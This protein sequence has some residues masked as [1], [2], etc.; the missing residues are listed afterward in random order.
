[1]RRL[2]G[3]LFV[4]VVILALLAGLCDRLWRSHVAQRELGEPRVGSESLSR[5]LLDNPYLEPDTAAQA[6]LARA[7]GSA[8]PVLVRVAEQGLSPLELRF[9]QL[10]QNWQNHLPPALRKAT[11]RWITADPNR[12]AKVMLLLGNLGPE[13]SNAVPTLLRL[14]RVDFM[15]TGQHARIALLKI[16]PHDPEVRALELAWLSSNSL[17]ASYYFQEAHCTY[18]EAPPILLR[19]LIADPGGTDNELLALTQYGA[20]ASNALPTVRTLFHAG[21][22]NALSVMLAMG[23]PAAPA[24]EE[25]AALLGGT[26]SMDLRILDGLRRIG[27]GAAITLPRVEPYLTA[28][29]PVTRLLAEATIASLRG[30]PTAVLPSFQRALEAHRSF[31]TPYDIS[32]PLLDDHVVYPLGS[33]GMACWFAGEMGPSAAPV[34][35]SLEA[36]FDDEH[37]QLRVLAA[38]GHWRIALQ[39]EQVLPVLRAVLRVPDPPVREL[40]ICALIE[41]GPP[42]AAAEPELRAI[43]TADLETRRL[44]NLALTKI[45]QDGH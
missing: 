18:P 42:A 43:R 14:A 3:Q 19:K 37:E 44:V 16:A 8:V 21:K 27:P 40:A 34:L 36:C 2:V 33:R 41:I 29:N 38:W 4:F 30:E 5:W 12:S 11:G 25:L 45:H 23:P 15:G 20:A 35:P 7:G 9:F 17:L 22:G 13:A 31:G 24:A 26:E 28:T 1:M 32:F 39:A 10:W 6:T